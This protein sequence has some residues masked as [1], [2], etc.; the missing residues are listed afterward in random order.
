MHQPSD[1]ALAAEAAQAAP[2]VVDWS[3][4]DADADGDDAGACDTLDAYAYG[5]SDDCEGTEAAVAAT[6]RL[7][8]R[9]EARMATLNDQQRAAVLHP[10]DGPLLILAAAGTGKTEVLTARIARIV[11]VCGVPAC[12]V[13]AMTF[14][15]RAAREM[16]E[17]AVRICVAIDPAR[18]MA[19]A[20]DLTIS[21]FHS[22]CVRILRMHP[23]FAG[24]GFTILDQPDAVR[25]LTEVLGA[26]DGGC[27]VNVKPSAVY[28]QLNAWRN[29]GLEPADVPPA[30]RREAD[31]GGGGSGS[32]RGAGNGGGKANAAMVTGSASSNVSTAWGGTGLGI[33]EVARRAYAPY[34]ARCAEDRLVDFADLLAHSVRLCRDEPDFLERLRDRWTH[35]LVDEFQD[36]NAVQFELVRLIVGEGLRV[37][38]VGDDNQTIH[39]HA[40]AK[41]EHILG[42]A[43]HFEGTVTLKLELN[44]RSTR[45]ILDAANNVIVRNKVRTDKTLLCTRPE[46]G[47]ETVQVLEF[48]DEVQE[49]EGVA[50]A[51]LA[52]CRGGRGG[53]EASP[54]VTSE[55]APE[56]TSKV[57]PKVVPR[58]A[59][60]SLEVTPAAPEAT[61]EAA[62]EAASE[63]APRRPRFRDCCVLYRINAMSAFVER[64]LLDAGVPY[65]VSG[66]HAFF[67]RAEVKDAMA[68]LEVTVN[69]RSTQHVLRALAMPPRG[70]GPTTVNQLKALAAQGRCGL[71]EAVS[72]NPGLFKGKQATGLRALM[73]AVRFVPS[74]PDPFAPVGP[75]Q[76]PSGA[77]QGPAGKL[78]SPAGK[79]SGPA[80]K[81]SRPAGTLSGPAGKL[82]G[83]AGTLSGPA[84]A[85]AVGGLTG[86]AGSRAVP[87]TAVASP[88]GPT[89]HTGP[90]GPTDRVDAERLADVVA[91]VVDRSGLVEYHEARKDD[92]RA[93]NVR[94]LV[95]VA[96][97]VVEEQFPEGGSLAE[98]V[99]SLALFAPER[100]GEDDPD[101]DGHVTLM[102]MH[103]SKG[104]EWPCVHVVG[105]SE[106]C[107][108]FVMSVREG[109]IEGERRLAYVALTR[110]RDRLVLSHS[111]RRMTFRGEEKQTRSRF[112][113]EMAAAPPLNP[114]ST[115]P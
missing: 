59:P 28:A 4:W 105:M 104:L 71:L 46:E 42:F 41:V 10:P 65:R 66:S 9:L 25:L 74:R 49:A 73:D 48:E 68:Y 15:N 50:K 8:D 23:E 62:P 43:K 54:E 35:V 89:G 84:A 112:V 67:D 96:R 82:S 31:E 88:A 106:G 99:Q 13:L 3:A 12:R 101:D 110:A 72:R 115:R 32:G 64:A 76:G 79:L 86:P 26:T 97:R 1:D 44:Y 5:D 24:G 16:R 51:I 92:E 113:D 100:E 22:T 98:L 60:A 69:P 61:S 40:G 33:D 53:V 38:V 81:L 52:R 111:K 56:V 37:T 75:R 83:P 58:A 57:T 39:E 36:T 55:G 19:R 17:R 78:S 70:V 7:A 87:V 11:G 95:A 108:P 6:A 47:A 30:R 21:T 103:R 94:E 91:A 18:G 107:M 63:A 102:S 34:R 77:R 90:T 2:D 80:G 109:K 29:A 93:S 20:R 27:P 114:P 14:S 45:H 85:L